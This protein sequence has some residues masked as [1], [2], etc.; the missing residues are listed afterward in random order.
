M[1]ERATIY[2]DRE[3]GIIAPEMYGHFIEHLGHCIYDGIWVGKKS[4]IPNIDGI[5]QEAVEVFKA[6]RA[7]VIRW[8]GNFNLRRARRVFSL[9]IRM[10]KIHLITRTRSNPGNKNAA[11]VIQK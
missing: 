7:P 3:R 5:R 10:L 1:T 9:P 2:T 8:P 11:W 4:K 6:V